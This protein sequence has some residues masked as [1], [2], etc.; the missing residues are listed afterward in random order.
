MITFSDDAGRT[1]TSGGPHA[2]R[3]PRVWDPWFR[4]YYSIF[5][6]NKQLS[7]I[8]FIYFSV[9]TQYFEFYRIDPR[10]LKINKTMLR[11]MQERSGKKLCKSLFAPRVLR[12]RLNFECWSNFTTISSALDLNADQILRAR[13]H[14]ESLSVC[15]RVVK[16]QFCP[17]PPFFL[18]WKSCLG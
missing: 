18:F 10:L 15:F 9:N 11:I 13:V 7:Y 8:N 2:A 3:R 6:F 1:N 5:L 4:A 16:L 17:P 14:F 12:S